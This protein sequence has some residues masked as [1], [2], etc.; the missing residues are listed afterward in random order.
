MLP[1]VLAAAIGGI[2]WTKKSKCVQ[3]DSKFTLNQECTVCG[4]LV[5]GG[6]GTNF[7][8]YTYRGAV[9]QSAARCCEAH[10]PQ[11]EKRISAAKTKIDQEI[12]QREADDQ[13]RKNAEARI[14]LVD[15][16]Y[17]KSYRGPMKPLRLNKAIQT[18]YHANKDDAVY[19]LKLKAAM[20]DCYVI[21][22][23]EFHPRTERIDN[24]RFS[25]WSASG[26]I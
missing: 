11:M 8:P 24:Y 22:R 25:T 17:P 16:P 26:V 9:L 20:A 6:C 12:E 2:V 10:I 4:H 5:C 18:D 15:D 23:M 3:C 1:F 7:E 21:Q 13:R 14:H 19:E